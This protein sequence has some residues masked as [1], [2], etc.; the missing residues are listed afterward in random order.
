MIVDAI[1][2]IFIWIGNGTTN[3]EKERSEEM[4]QTYVL[5]DPTDRPKDYV[6]IIKIEQGDEPEDFKKIFPVWNNELFEVG[7]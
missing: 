4:A 7:N 3:C 2:K 1:D 5:N 6:P